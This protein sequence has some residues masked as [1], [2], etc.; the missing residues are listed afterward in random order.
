MNKPFLLI[1]G[2]NCLPPSSGTSEWQGCYETKEEIKINKISK[3]DP[4]INKDKYPRSHIINDFSYE[5]DG[6]KFDWYTIV[7]LR[8]WT[9]K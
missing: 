3:I 6:Q 5:I 8:D 1:A 2:Y 9:N 7:D 4:L